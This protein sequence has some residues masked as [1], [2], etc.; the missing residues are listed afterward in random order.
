MIHVSP[1]LLCHWIN[2]NKINIYKIYIKLWILL[3]V[4]I[5]YML[6]ILIFLIKQYQNVYYYLLYNFF[7]TFSRVF[8]NFRLIN[9]LCK[10]IYH[11]SQ[12]PLSF[13]LIT[14]AL[15]NLP[16]NDN[17]FQLLIFL[18][19]ISKLCLVHHKFERKYK[20]KKIKR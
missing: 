13:Q 1:F 7:L 20:K 14:H 8:I 3:L 16:T 6:H 17:Y 11:Y 5:N 9:I 18:L 10:N 4:I 15:S 2:P 19:W 12:S